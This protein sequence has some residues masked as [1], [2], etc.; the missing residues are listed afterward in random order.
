ALLAM[1]L[2]MPEE[3]IERLKLLE[4]E[5]GGGKRARM[6]LKSWAFILLSLLL[7]SLCF[8]WGAFPLASSP[9]L[10]SLPYLLEGGERAWAA[11]LG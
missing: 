10:A 5:R 6:P 9:L 7:C 3:K 4:K 2:C 1:A 8:L 11:A